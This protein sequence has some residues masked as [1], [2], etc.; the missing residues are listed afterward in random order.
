MNENLFTP[1]T[2]P[3]ILSQPA[4]VPIILFPVLLFPTSKHLIKNQLITIQ[5]NVIQ[6]ILKQI[7]IIHNTKGQTWSLILISLIIFFVISNLLGLLPHSFTST[8]QLSINLA[9]AIPLWAGTVIIG[10]RFKTKSSSAHFLPQGT[11]TPRIPIL[12]VIETISLFIQLVA[13]A[14]RLTTNITAGHLLMHLIRSA[15]LALSTISFPATS[16]I[17]IL[18]VLLTILEITVT[19][20]QAYVFTCLVSLYLH[21]NT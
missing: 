8:T 2:A 9:I 1:S 20:I 15:T 5:Q 13:L 7:I 4:A 3:T 17:F 6:L 10:L 16:L 12:V 14:V 18:P 11:P 21:D 19:L